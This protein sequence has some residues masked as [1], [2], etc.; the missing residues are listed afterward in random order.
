[1]DEHFDQKPDQSEKATRRKARKKDKE[2][3]QSRRNP[4]PIEPRSRAQAQ[5]IKSLHTNSLTFGIGPAGT[6]KTFVPSRVFGQMLIRREIERICISRPPVARSKHRMGFLPGDAEEK[7]APWLIPV[8][9]GLK[10]SM[11]PAE[12]DRLRRENRIEVV[13]F[14]FMQ[15][16]TFKNA[17]WI[18]D[19]AE[20][21]DLD[22]LYITLTRQGENLRT[23][24][25][26]D[27]KQ[28]R[29]NNSGL[30]DVVNM[31]QSSDIEDTG[32][33]VFGEEDVVR[34]LQAKQWVKAFNR[35]NLFDVTNCDMNGVQDFQEN[36]PGFL[37]KDS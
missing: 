5:Y 18:V 31:A 34:S 6:G 11:A 37:R 19:E 27:F 8:F 36:P 35:L 23:C 28:A 13:P 24:I 33:V 10:E 22:D 26:G 20:N 32:V 7:T 3:R 4:K 25:S 14:E 16:R 9:E 12:F 2:T 29:I 17:A 15:G 1:M 21:L 30:W